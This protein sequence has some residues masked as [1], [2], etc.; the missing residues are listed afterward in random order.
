[1]Q[2]GETLHR[3][4]S[5]IR[6][7]RRTFFLP[8]PSTPHNSFRRASRRAAPACDQTTTRAACCLISTKRTPRPPAMLA[9]NVPSIQGRALA[10]PRSRAEARPARCA[11]PVQYPH[12][13]LSD[14][15]AAQRP[16][17]F[18]VPGHSRITRYPCSGGLSEPQPGLAET[19]I[20]AVRPDLQLFRVPASRFRRS[21]PSHP[22]SPPLKG[23]R[24]SFRP[25]LASLRSARRPLPARPSAS[26]A[27]PPHSDAAPKPGRR[28]ARRLPLSIPHGVSLIFSHHSRSPA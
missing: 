25:G 18:S 8:L 1:M 5:F 23:V 3:I 16:R 17:G 19:V 4:P 9:R 2:P 13:V 15:E 11:I 10:C 12:C 20:C 6:E 14:A 22:H 21:L 27:P 24:L 28:E 7:R 26:A